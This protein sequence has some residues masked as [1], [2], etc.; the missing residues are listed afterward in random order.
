MIASHF[1]PLPFAFVRI[2]EPIT[3]R[4]FWK[5]DGEEIDIDENR[6]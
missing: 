3:R 5:M 2:S 6:N 1:D 4:K